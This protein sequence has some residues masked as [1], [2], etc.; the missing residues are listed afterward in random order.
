MYD[1]RLDFLP[2]EPGGAS[3]MLIGGFD[4]SLAGRAGGLFEHTVI[5]DWDPTRF[6]ASKKAFSG[7]SIELVELEAGAPVF[8]TGQFDLIMVFWAVSYLGNPARWLHLLIERLLPR[9]RLAVIDR[10]DR[11]GTPEQELTYAKEVGAGSIC[12][13]TPGPTVVD[14]GTP[15][16]PDMS[17]ID[18]FIDPYWKYGDSVVEVPDYDTKIIPPSGVVMITSYWMIIGET[19]KNL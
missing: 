5:A 14:E 6:A 4:E 15:V 8:P 18:I 12:V 1:E 13:L 17:L 10:V 3:L 16:T 9:G 19:L 11:T 7:K 2:L